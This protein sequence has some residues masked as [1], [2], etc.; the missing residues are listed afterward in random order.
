MKVQNKVR[1]VSKSEVGI[2]NLMI[3]EKNQFQ[4]IL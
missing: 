4:K 2:H 3:N 1:N